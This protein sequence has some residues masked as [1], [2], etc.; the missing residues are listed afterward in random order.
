M[1]HY[2]VKNS[3]KYEE[4][5]RKSVYKRDIEFL[6]REERED[7]ICT[8]T[9]QVDVFCRRHLR[10]ADAA[11]K[12]GDIYF[13]VVDVEKTQRK[14]FSW[15]IEE[16]KAQRVSR[17]RI[18]ERESR[19]RQIKGTREYKDADLKAEN[20]FDLRKKEEE[21]GII[22]GNV[23]AIQIA[24]L[25][26]EKGDDTFAI[27]C[28]RLVD[29][30]TGLP[31]LPPS[32][33][34]LLT[35][36]NVVLINVNQH[37]DIDGILSSFYRRPIKGIVYIDAADLFNSLWGVGWAG[38]NPDG[39]VKTQPSALDIVEEALPGFTYYKH[40]KYTM[41]E[42]M[43]PRWSPGQVQYALEDV[44]V[45]AMA[46]RA[47]M[48]ERRNSEEVWDHIRVFPAPS[49]ASP[50]TKSKKKKGGFAKDAMKVFFPSAAD[51]NYSE[52]FLHKNSYAPVADEII[53]AADRPM[54]SVAALRNA[55]AASSTTGERRILRRSEEPTLAE[56]T[57]PTPVPDRFN[58]RKVL[59][60]TYDDVS[61]DEDWEQEVEEEERITFSYG[62]TTLKGLVVV[63]E[64]G[65][66]VEEEA[67]EEAE[68]VAAETAETAET[69][70]R[71]AGEIRNDLEI[72]VDADDV[73]DV[74]AERLEDDSVLKIGALDAALNAA[75]KPGA[76]KVVSTVAAAASDPIPSDNESSIDPDDVMEDL[77]A[78]RPPP[79]AV[80]EPLAAPLTPDPSAASEVALVH[81]IV[82][83]SPQAPVVYPND[84]Y[85]AMELGIDISDS[86]LALCE[87]GGFPPPF[88][89]RSEAAADSPSLPAPAPAPLAICAPNDAAN[90]AAA[91]EDS[92]AAPSTSSSRIGKR[93]YAVTSG[94]SLI[95]D[96]V[97]DAIPEVTLDKRAINQVR[98]FRK[99]LVHNS[100]RA[101]EFELVDRRF[102]P[103]VL[104]GTLTINYIMKKKEADRASALVRRLLHLF[105]YEEKR[106]FLKIVALNPQTD[107]IVWFDMIEWTQ[108]DALM[109]VNSGNYDV[110]V[111]RVIR[112]L[113]DDPAA[114]IAKL[115][116]WVDFKRPQALDIFRQSPFNNKT[117]EGFNLG[118][119]ASS[120]IEKFIQSISG[121]HDLPFPAIVTLSNVPNKLDRL[122]SAFPKQELSPRDLILS[123]NQAVDSHPDVRCVAD[124][125][126]GCS[127]AAA[128][129]ECY[130]DAPIEEI[131][132]EDECWTSGICPS[133]EYTVENIDDASKAAALIHRL[134]GVKAPIPAI[135]RLTNQMVRQQ[136]VVAVMMQI[137]G[138]KTKFRLDTLDVIDGFKLDVLRA[139][140]SKSVYTCDINYVV[141]AATYTFGL[142]EEYIGNSFVRIGGDSPRQRLMLPGPRVMAKSMGQKYCPCTRQRVVCDE[143]DID[144]SFVWHMAHELAIL[145]RNETRKRC[146][147]R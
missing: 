133:A 73:A 12:R 64:I 121:F 140:F 98:S 28:L 8:S 145:A 50:G 91:A 21:E 48:P 97:S 33:E 122:A 81:E 103:E 99:R 79:I 61:A 128:T 90:A 94:N 83:A 62:H 39:Q 10:R 6:S 5:R 125:V 116:S 14:E 131:P 67:E 104:A 95:L 34:A 7:R 138:A 32:L 89:L 22:P 80:D 57:E 117:Y 78:A 63:D 146:A 111:R 56:S 30:K 102:L 71:S 84:T 127:E 147:K 49:K 85:V 96:V 120:R 29:S 141:R 105:S 27:N 53:A 40:P 65:G 124:S 15:H 16:L 132:H 130:R 115:A 76:W 18:G 19:Q 75:P 60:Y 66:E 144:A 72:A 23:A 136:R 139:L 41:G 69:A 58:P 1:P 42:W 54:T 113:E 2:V 77:D 44:H 45:P 126:I 52:D 51:D 101:A 135:F 70:E 86:E 123:I 37:E 24:A 93:R 55:A 143:K 106:R 11:A 3:E 31:A 17:T 114:L 4:R 13:I 36:D 110:I 129:Y 119:L 25:D 109:V 9:K 134:R 46:F 88:K 38:Y 142:D 43:V 82:V 35:A 137:P 108:F 47:A 20:Y 92:N 87:E 26:D 59:G 74:R 68:E 112:R 100:L 107:M 118:K